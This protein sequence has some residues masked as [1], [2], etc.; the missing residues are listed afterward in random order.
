MNVDKDFFR[1]LRELGLGEAETMTYIALLEIENASIRKLAAATNIN[2]GTTYDALKQLVALGLCSIKQTGK[3]EAYTAE[4]PERVYELIRDKRRDLLDV[5]AAA[6][7]IIPRILARQP[8]PDGR[9]IVRYYEGDDGIVSILKDVLQT[10]SRQD[11]PIYYAYSSKHIRQFLYRKF[12]QFTDRRVAAQI[13]VKVIATE[14]DHEP[15][16]FSERKPLSDSL[17]GSS[18]CYSLIYGNKVA[19]ISIS[20]NLTPYGVVIEDQGAASMQQLLFE[21]LWDNLPSAAQT[22]GT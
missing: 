11:N 14:V 19:T 1:L 7:T 10:C 21:Q 16:P 20:S 15:A 5:S 22:T 18:M 6:K 17:S 3:R 9:P 13:M 2:R 12:P 8:R 4:S